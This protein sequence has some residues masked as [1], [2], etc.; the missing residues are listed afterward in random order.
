MTDRLHIQMS[1]ESDEE[2]IK[3]EI[4]EEY[5]FL[6]ETKWRMAKKDIDTIITL[7]INMARAYPADLEQIRDF[8]NSILVTYDIDEITIEI[9]SNKFRVSDEVEKEDKVVKE[10]NKKRE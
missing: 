3:N 1:S 6:V 9:D 10:L 4:L 8:I 7:A 2:E 5:E